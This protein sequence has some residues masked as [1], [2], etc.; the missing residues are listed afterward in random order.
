MVSAVSS[1]SLLPSVGLLL[2]GLGF[3]RVVEVHGVSLGVW[4]GIYE[5]KEVNI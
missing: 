2:C 5:Q 4:G 1:V 3:A